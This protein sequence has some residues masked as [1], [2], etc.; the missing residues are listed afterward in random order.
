MERGSGERGSG[1]TG[2]AC[3]AVPFFFGGVARPWV[4][5]FFGGVSDCQTVHPAGR[6]AAP[7][8]SPAG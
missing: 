2:L 6:K 8:G 5:R 3:L 1:I 7:S 4:Y